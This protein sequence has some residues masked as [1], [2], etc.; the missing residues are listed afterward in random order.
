[1]SDSTQES[2]TSP[3]AFL[4][5]LGNNIQEQ[6][7]ID[8]ELARILAEYILRAEPEKDAAANAASAITQLAMFRAQAMEEQAA[9]E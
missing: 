3:A 1:M 8:I 6:S 5:D 7:S 2:T 4:D 9:N